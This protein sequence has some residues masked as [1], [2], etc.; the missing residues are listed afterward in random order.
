[1]Q[2]LTYAEIVKLEPRLL[3]A[4]AL[5]RELSGSKTYEPW[6]G[7]IKSRF[8]V[9]VGWLSKHPDQR[10]HSSEA[11]NVVY[12]T[13]M[14]IYEQ[15][16]ATMDKPEITIDDTV[17]NRIPFGAEPDDDGEDRCG[18]CGVAHGEFHRPNCDQER[19]PK[20]HGQLISCDCVGRIVGADDGEGE[21]SEDPAYDMPRA[22]ESSEIG[23]RLARVAELLQFAATGLG[24]MGQGGQG[25]SLLLQEALNELGAV[26]ECNVMVMEQAIPF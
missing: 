23:R 9:L 11:Y 24:A 21:E 6:Y 8:K 25:P 3:E 22:L 16:N 4:E 13:L 10:L 18:D 7:E 20:C 1:M 26:S 2:S 5:A 17:Y 15:E 12:S 14:A 19:C